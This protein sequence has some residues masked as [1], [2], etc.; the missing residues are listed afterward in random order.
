V[1]PTGGARY[2]RQ[3]R[4]LL[5]RGVAAGHVEEARRHPDGTVAHA[6]LHETLHGLELIGGGPAVR[7]A[8]DALA[9]GAV[10]DEAG[11]IHRSTRRL[12][13]LEERAQRHGR[14]AV[15]AVEQRRHP[16]PE[17]VVRGGKAED[18]GT[19]MGMDV[20][21]ARRDDVPADVD[22]ACR[23][24]LQPAADR[25]DG[26][27]ADPDVRAV[28]GGAGPVDD[29]AAAKDDVVPRGLRGGRRRQEGHAETGT[30][31]GQTEHSCRHQGL[32]AGSRA[33]PSCG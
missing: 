26:V 24:A 19:G 20:D 15:D 6:L 10:P 25:H 12:H 22:H 2:F 1:D 11:E 28:P 9:D 33:M 23:P 30:D 14:E 18:P 7:A 8:K 3:G 31:R 29:P 13:L 27:A 32:L 17:A 16:L 4:H 5:R 21:E